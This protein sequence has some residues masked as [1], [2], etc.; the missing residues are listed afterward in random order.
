MLMIFF[1]STILMNKIK[2]FENYY[3]KRLFVE[4]ERIKFFS[5]II[6]NYLDEKKYIFNITFFTIHL[7]TNS[8]NLFSLT[9]LIIQ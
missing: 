1:K 8:I 9:H 4:N 7:I 3:S 2:I 5:K 6:Y